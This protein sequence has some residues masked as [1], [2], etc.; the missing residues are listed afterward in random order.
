MYECGLPTSTHNIVDNFFRYPWRQSPRVAK[1][2]A[3]DHEISFSFVE[4]EISLRIH[5]I[6]H[7]SLSS[8]NWIQPT[9]SQNTSPAFFKQQLP[10]RVSYK[11]FIC[12]CYTFP[13]CPAFSYRLI[14]FYLVICNSYK[15]YVIF[16]SLL[17]YNFWY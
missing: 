15:Y 4:P 9:H 16:G 11:N 1:N 14:F 6:T 7:W 2:S 12:I 8:A 13:K 5:E 10:F 3:A 17:E